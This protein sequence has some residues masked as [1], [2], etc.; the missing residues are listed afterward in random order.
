MSDR[1]VSRLRLFY[2]AQFIVIGIQVPFFPV[3][4][5]ARG[6]DPRA[7]GLI[8]AAPMI[9]RVPIV[10]LATRFADRLGAV[11][12]ALAATAA[13]AL[14]F[15]M[16]AGLAEGFPAL[17]VAVV[18]ALIAF[19]MTFPFADAYALR[20]LAERGRS[21]G[22]A[23]LWGSAAFIAANVGGGF[24][25]GLIP[26]GAL[27]WLIAA[28]CAVTAIMAARLVA[29]TPEPPAHGEPAAAH[30][31]LWRTPAFVAAIAATSL[32]QASHSVYYSF[33]AIDWAAKGLEGTTIGVLW[34]LGVLAEIVL[35]ALSGRLPKMIGAVELIGIGALGA[36]LRWGVMALDPPLLLLPVLQ[37]LHA[38]SFGATYLGTMQF[39]VRIAP[40]QMA[41]TAQGD[42]SAVQGVVVA[43]ATGLSGVLY[44]AYG[45]LAYAAM[46]GSALAGGLLV[47]AL[48][49]T[50]RGKG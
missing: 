33:S 9:M 17:F 18:A 7:I 12:G 10:P 15:Y 16:L 40:P 45:G 8:L 34:A 43:G 46:A 39:L 24:V 38:L 41:A 1:F 42:L 30:G 44:E 14:V 48:A 47:I 11:R 35:F 2:A 49:S 32:I 50:T 20:G 4:L 22:S 26:A 25:L 23:R 36:V 3:W 28:A 6:L 31:V 13:I 37:C 29:S 5:D 19:G 27:I 21:Y